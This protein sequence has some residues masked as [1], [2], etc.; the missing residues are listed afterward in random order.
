MAR[1]KDKKVVYQKQAV[2]FYEEDAELY[3][4]LQKEVIRTRSSMRSVILNCLDEHFIT[5]KTE[6]PTKSNKPVGDIFG[7]VED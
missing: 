4:A 1:A 7:N 2:V 5:E 6:I 3:E